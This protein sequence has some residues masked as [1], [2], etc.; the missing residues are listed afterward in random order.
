MCAHMLFNSCLW[1]FIDVLYV[2]VCVC[3]C[4]CEGV[5]MYLC[6][7]L[8]AVS[9]RLQAGQARTEEKERQTKRESERKRDHVRARFRCFR[10]TW[11]GQW[12]E[13]MSR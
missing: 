10:F 9:S 6:V 8:L 5:S 11:S 7:S 1:V 12:E 4:V 13:I 2:D 3:V